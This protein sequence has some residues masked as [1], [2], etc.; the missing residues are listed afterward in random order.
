MSIKF[1]NPL[2]SFLSMK[3]EYLHELNITSSHFSEFTNFVLIEETGQCTI[4]TNEA[5]CIINLTSVRTFQDFKISSCAY[6]FKCKKG[7]FYHLGTFPCN[8]FS[9]ILDACLL[10]EKLDQLTSL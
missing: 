5:A 8:P 6:S 4:Y 9:K 7:T 10:Q 1:G 2:A 3:W